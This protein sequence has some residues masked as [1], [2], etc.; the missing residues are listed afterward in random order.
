VGLPAWRQS[1][2]RQSFHGSASWASSYL[3]QGTVA[4]LLGAVQLGQASQL[5]V[6]EYLIRVLRRLLWH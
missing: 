5:D 1:Q 2:G 3:C 4:L 6:L